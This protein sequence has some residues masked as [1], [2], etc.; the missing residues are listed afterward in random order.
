MNEINKLLW[1]EK[2]FEIGTEHLRSAFLKTSRRMVFVVG[3]GISM[4]SGIPSGNDLHEIARGTLNS[5]FKD[6]KNKKFK[7]LEEFLD[8][9]HNI[10]PMDSERA[11][12]EI[13]SD[14]GIPGCENVTN[15]PTLG[16]L[17]VARL[18]Q[19]GVANTVIS[20]NFDE[21]LE[22]CIEA[23]LGERGDKWCYIDDTDGFESMEDLVYESEKQAKCIFIKPHGTISKR[24]L[25]AAATSVK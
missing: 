8:H 3:A 10:L 5:I 25:L 9:I 7:T 17:S 1:V 20:L 24:N 19:G 15:V 6:Q 22:R 11:I 18:I 16:H 12:S 23:E 4:E 21:L 14:A 2:P 13:L